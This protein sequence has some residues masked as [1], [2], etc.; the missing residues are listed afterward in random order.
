MESGLLL[1]KEKLWRKVEK[2]LN[3]I[4]DHSPKEVQAP[5]VYIAT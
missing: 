1:S 2:D 3:K 5:P 4:T